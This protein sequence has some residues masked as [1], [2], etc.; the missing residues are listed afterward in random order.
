MSAEPDYHRE[1]AASR[2]VVGVPIDAESQR[3]ETGTGSKSGWRFVASRLAVSMHYSP[4][5]DWLLTGKNLVQRGGTGKI[6]VSRHVTRAYVEERYPDAL[7]D[8]LAALDN[9]AGMV[10][11]D[12]ARACAQIAAIRAGEPVHP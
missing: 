9:L 2:W 8:M 6:T 4:E 12:A 7:A 3:E 10:R 1:S 11:T 5:P